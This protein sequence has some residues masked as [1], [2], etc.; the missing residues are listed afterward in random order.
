VPS[1]DPNDPGYRR[2]RYV[3][4]ADDWLLGLSGP[5]CE[6]EDIKREIG[7]FLRD[8]LKLELSETKTLIT[9]ARTGSARFLGYDIAVLHHDRKLDRRGH[10]CINGQIGLTVP[11]VVVKAKGT[12]YLSHG[13]PIHRPEL[14]HDTPYSI[15]AQ[16]Q[17][18]YRGIVEYY[19]MA[20]NL[21]QL[22][23]L[24]WVMERSLTQTLAL[25]F[26]TS[27]RSVYRR[28]QATF[29]AEG[30]SY[31]VLQ[32]TVERGEGRKPLVARWG[33]ISLAWTIQS[34]LNE[35]PPRIYGSHT[36]LEQRL[37]ASQCELCGSMEHVQVHHV[38]AL[39]DLRIRG[40]KE[41]PFW[42]RVMTARRRKTLV[43]CAS[44]HNAL[45]AGRLTTPTAANG[46]TLES[47]VLRKA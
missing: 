8:H 14:I 43:V 9:H 44:C 21:H 42:M 15:V 1:L 2:L 22:N 39:K 18:E 37:L 28:L 17:Q 33:G 4:Y 36:E 27:V 16:Y 40:R 30:G 31:T 32:V 29:V 34:D 11:A 35:A 19:R 41:K 46:T 6:A 3:R 45:H 5:R 26:K 25:K 47:R 38:R 20:Y 7:R 12:R 13:K 10:R 23:R 24:K